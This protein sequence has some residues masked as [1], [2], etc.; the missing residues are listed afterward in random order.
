MVLLRAT[1]SVTIAEA[2]SVTWERSMRLTVTYAYRSGINNEL[3]T[4]GFVL[5]K[6]HEQRCSLQAYQFDLILRTSC[7]QDKGHVTHRDDGV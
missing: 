6:I 7:D 1:A 4:T 3:S 2:L 5:I